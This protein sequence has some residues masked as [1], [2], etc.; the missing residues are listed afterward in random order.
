MK[1][2]LTYYLNKEY[3]IL[4]DILMQTDEIKKSVKKGDIEYANRLFSGR[5]KNLSH[6]NKYQDAIVEIF[7]R[8]AGDPAANTKTNSLKEKVFDLLGKIKSLDDEI[9][10]MLSKGYAEFLLKKS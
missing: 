3:E 10:E 7:K 1:N 2:K 8:Q 9:N 4:N 5:S 6:A